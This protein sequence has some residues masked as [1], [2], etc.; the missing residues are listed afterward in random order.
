MP[1]IKTKTARDKLTPRPGAYFETLSKGRALGFRRGPD[2]WIARKYTPHGDK[3]FDYKPLGQFDDYTAA[4]KAA[5]AW[6]GMASGTAHRSAKRGTVRAAL[7]AYLLHLRSVGRRSTARSAAGTFKLVIDKAFGYL[8]LE[9]LT[10]DDVEEWRARHKSGRAPR[11]LN[12]YVRDVVAAL[13]CAVDE[14]KHVGNRDAWVLTHLSDDDESESAV[15][16]SADQRDWLIAVA[17]KD[18]A[19]LLTGYTHLGC[20]PSELANATVAD[21]DPIGGTVSVRHRKGRGSHVRVRAVMLS[22]DG[23]EFFK[24][25]ARRKAPA[26][27]LVA[28][29][30][31]THWHRV[32]WARGIRAAAAAANKKAKKA[33]Q[34]IPA[35]VSAYSFRHTRISEL[36]QLGGV[37]PLTVA[38]QCGTSVGQIEK[39]YYKFIASTMRAKLNAMKAA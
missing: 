5:E 36:L 38:V 23:I 17:P 27:P 25:Q 7:A 22:S 3:P 30:D 39:H 32:A 29:D 20:R 31:G 33:A 19:A 11:S 35:D 21:F 28:R 18:L 10:R 1:N 9:D 4:K 15:F 2:T 26:D 13:N 8:R 12:R 24:A 34:R 6:F 16:L 14:C 37:D